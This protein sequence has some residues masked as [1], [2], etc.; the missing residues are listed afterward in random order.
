MALQMTDSTHSQDKENTE[1]E[2]MD[3]K[4]D[5]LLTYNDLLIL[6]NKFDRKNSAINKQ[7]L[8]ISFCLEKILMYENERKYREKMKKH[9]TSSGE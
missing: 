9:E 5:L 1:N 4:K 6:I 7:F 3:L 2:F 8:K